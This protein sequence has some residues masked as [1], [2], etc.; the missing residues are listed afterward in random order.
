MAKWFTQ[1]PAVNATFIGFCPE[2][3]I[4]ASIKRNCIFLVKKA[5]SP[6]KPKLFPNKD[7]SGSW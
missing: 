3:R 4:A 7:E 5:A 6:F 2:E 1:P